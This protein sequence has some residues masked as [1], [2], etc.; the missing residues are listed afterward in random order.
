MTH[1]YI[2]RHGQAQSAVEERVAGIKGDTGLSKLGV[3]QA[4]R[5]RDRLLATKEIK[6]DVFIASNIPRARQTAEII[7]PAIG[8]PLLLDEEV[9]E[10]RPGEADGL[11][12]KEYQ[13]R[14]PRYWRDTNPFAELSPGGESWPEFVL[15]ASRSL[16]RITTEH[17]GKTI[18]LVCHGGIIQSSFLYFFG[19]PI[20]V[21]PA[22]IEFE[23][24]N[25][26]ITHWERGNFYIKDPTI[27]RWRLICH[28]DDFH[29]RDPRFWQ[30]A[31]GRG[32]NIETEDTKQPSIAEKE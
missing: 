22:V 8:L 24:K 20:V 9:Q 3:E 26:S 12:V 14:Y 21:T 30:S 2:I 27:E 19:S 23:T 15:R 4:T 7:A 28:N 17:A 16:E 18:V 5:L 6:A 10:L 29:L 31:D 32:G 13:E 25:T 1:L 11:R